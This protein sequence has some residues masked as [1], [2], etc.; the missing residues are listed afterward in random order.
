[1]VDAVDSAQP[2][3]LVSESAHDPRPRVL[4]LSSRPTLRVGGHRPGEPGAAPSTGRPPAIRLPAASS[5]GGPGPLGLAI[6]GL[7]GVAVESC[8]RTARDRPRL[9]PPR[10]P[11]LLAMEVRATRRGPPSARR[12]AS[13]SHSAHGSREPHLGPSADP[14]RTRPAGVRRGRPD[15]REVHAPDVPSA[16][17]TLARLILSPVRVAQERVTLS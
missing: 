7:G 16:L 1:M 17:T 12:R 13:P 15:H 3:C 6:P 4:N 2:A 11:A 8:H 10:F 14:G 5:A 9:A